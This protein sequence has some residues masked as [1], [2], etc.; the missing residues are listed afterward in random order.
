MIFTDQYK[1]DLNSRD[2]GYFSIHKNWTIKKSQLYHISGKASK[3]SLSTAGHGY[4]ARYNRD[5]FYAHL[6]W[7]NTNRE[8]AY[9]GDICVIQWQ[10]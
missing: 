9:V 6:G 5:K 2:F 3:N 10:D 8:R 7:K 4:R 1:K